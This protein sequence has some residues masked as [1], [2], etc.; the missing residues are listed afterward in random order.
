MEG[1][2]LA[3]VY[4]TVLSLASIQLL[5]EIERVDGRDNFIERQSTQHSTRTLLAA[6]SGDDRDPPPS[7][8]GRYQKA[9][10]TL[11][12]RVVPLLS[13]S[14]ADTG[15][16]SEFRRDQADYRTYERMRRIRILESSRYPC[17]QRTAATCYAGHSR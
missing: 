7:L 17:A 9:F 15:L 6:R 16:A 1:S 14:K 12:S 8:F 10:I 3:V 13:T 11:C 4:G 5:R 2:T